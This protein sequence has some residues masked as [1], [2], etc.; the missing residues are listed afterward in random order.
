MGRFTTLAA[1][2]MVAV[3]ATPGAT[4]SLVS[5]TTDRV[6]QFRD[7]VAHEAQHMRSDDDAA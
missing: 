4:K 3:Q 5:T 6:K 2:T 7:D 1:K